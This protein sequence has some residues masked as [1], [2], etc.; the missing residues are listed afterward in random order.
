LGNLFAKGLILIKWLGDVSNVSYDVADLFLI[1][2]ASPRRDN[3]TL[4]H[5]IA[6]LLDDAQEKFV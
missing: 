4:S 6:P 5:R 1:N 3:Y 2:L